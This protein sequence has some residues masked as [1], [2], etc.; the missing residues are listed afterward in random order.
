M[1]RYQYLKIP[2]HKNPATI[3]YEVTTKPYDSSLMMVVGV[4]ICHDK[5]NFSK[6]MGRQIADGRRVKSPYYVAFTGLDP[7]SS[8]GKRIVSSIHG[9]FRSEWKKIIQEP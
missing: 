1:A 7:A 4:A 3:S 5:D 9:W 8:F 6:E 2:G